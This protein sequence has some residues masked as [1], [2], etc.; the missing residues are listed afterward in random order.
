M[1]GVA[2]HPTDPRADAWLEQP[3]HALIRLGDDNYPELLS[4]ISN[5]PESLYIKGDPEALQLPALA[6]VGSRNPTSGGARNAFEFARYLANNGFCIVSGLAQGIDSAAHK[7]A[8]AASKPTVAFL[9][10]GIDTVYPAQNRELAEAISRNG[11]L[12]SEFP[13]GTPPMKE[14]FPQR[15][16]LISGASL[17]TL[18]VEAARRSGSLITAR[19]AGEQGREVFAIP[20]SIH[21]AMAR[22]C[23]RLIRD[24][25]KLVESADDILGEL[26]PLVGHVLQ[27]AIA[28]DNL[29]IQQKPRDAEYVKLLENLG[30]D[31]ISVDQLVERSGL[32]IG[33]VSSMLLILELDGTVEKLSGGR[34]IL[35][36]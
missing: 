35:M 11:A 2:T 13:L 21:N 12:V 8:I 31:P 34:Y 18:V 1:A 26:G 5:P 32:T 6:I 36:S 10:H 9:G 29:P 3:G 19:L 17:G 33:Q 24:G 15:N 30:H 25:A 22:G 4:R 16:R 7:G 28:T 27:N 20:G 14:L 23:H